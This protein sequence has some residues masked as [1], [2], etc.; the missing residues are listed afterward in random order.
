MNDACKRYKFI[1]F[2]M[3]REIK[4]RVWHIESKKYILCRLEFLSYVAFGSIELIFEQYTGLKDKNGKEIYEGDVLEL[5]ANNYWYV[6]WKINNARFYL[7]SSFV[8]KNDLSDW[9]DGRRRI[10]IGVYHNDGTIVG[11]IQENPELLNET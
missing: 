8:H 5:S 9:K 1:R 10:E 6:E 4:F 2:D 7:T 3:S 11:N